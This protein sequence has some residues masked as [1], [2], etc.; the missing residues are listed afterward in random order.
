MANLLEVGRQKT[1]LKMRAY[2]TEFY[3]EWLSRVNHM[4]IL[5]H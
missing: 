3:S 1:L 5:F 2:D 4:V